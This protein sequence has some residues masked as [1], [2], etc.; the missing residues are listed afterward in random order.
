MK[1][2][3][4]TMLRI[5]CLGL[6]AA[7]PG[8]VAPVHAQPPSASPPPP[9]V[10]VVGVSADEQD[11]VI[12]MQ[13][14]ETEPL[15]SSASLVVMSTDGTVRANQ[16]LSPSSGDAE[17]VLPAV[18]TTQDIGVAFQ[19]SVV[20]AAQEPLSALPFDL[21]LSCDTPSDCHL[22]ARPGFAAAPGS[23]VISKDMDAA[24]TASLSST[25]RLQP[26]VLG[27][28]MA[29]DP[30]LTGETYT[31]GFIIAKTLPLLPVN[32][33]LC[34]WNTVNFLR[35][36]TATEVRNDPNPAHQRG[37]QGPGAA[38]S[39]RAWYDGGLFGAT[40]DTET[41]VE[42]ETETTMKLRCQLISSWRLTVIKIFGHD[43]YVYVPIIERSCPGCAGTVDNYAEYYAD[44][45]A[46]VDAGWLGSGEAAAQEEGLFTVNGQ[47]VLNRISRVGK[48]V[49]KQ[50][51][52]A[53]SIPGLGSIEED[54][55]KVT[56][57]GS[58][59]GPF[60]AEIKYE[61]NGNDGTVEK[62]IVSSAAK[63]VPQPATALFQSKAL[64]Y[65]KGSSDTD[66]EGKSNMSYLYAMHG[67]ALC[68]TPT[69]AAMWNYYSY[70]NRTPQLKANIKI[71]F[72]QFGMPVNP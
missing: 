3:L 34:S 5:A 28:V 71:F 15:P 51:A 58:P 2:Q 33:C 14:S 24:L 9:V 45:S 46:F 16:P 13:W 30:A 59:S 64:A 32:R 37:W 6:F 36:S 52:F 18:L 62:K 43:Y 19:A 68:A 66:S 63:T 20:D 7:S 44:T 4:R 61:V 35:P 41:Y 40:H 31:Y 26:D 56:V 65:A 55:G 47:A 42:G 21:V 53:L 27:D 10:Q 72:N 57:K 17:V 22:Q 48:E 60:K 8:A 29:R 39:L 67:R 38:H 1:A 23:Q 54:N 50:W 70:N 49:R 11:L 69:D 12:K 25:A